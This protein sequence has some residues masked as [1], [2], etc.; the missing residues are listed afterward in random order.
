[1]TCRNAK[2][3]I[4]RKMEFQWARRIALTGTD[5]GH[6]VYAKKYISQV[7]DGHHLYPKWAMEW[8]TPAITSLS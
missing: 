1:M 8:N 4:S 5:Y 6:I 3:Q 2:T 7:S